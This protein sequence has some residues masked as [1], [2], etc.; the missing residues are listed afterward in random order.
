MHSSTRTYL[1][2]WGGLKSDRMAAVKAVG[3][4]TAI[5]ANDLIYLIHIIGWVV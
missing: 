3:V 4:T 2:P 5:Y 1:Y